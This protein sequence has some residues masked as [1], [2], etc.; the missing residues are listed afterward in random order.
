MQKN[1]YLCSDFCVHIR[2]RARVRKKILSIKGVQRCVVFLFLFSCVFP[3]KAQIHEAHPSLF[4]ASDSYH[5]G[6]V[7]VG[8]GYTNLQTA[9]PNVTP[10]GDVGGL[11]GIG[12]EYRNRFL[13][14][15]A[16]VQMSLFHSSMKVG[17]ER[18]DFNG[19]DTQGKKA[20]FHYDVSQRDQLSWTMFDLPL[21]AG[22]YW[23]G[24]QVGVG[25]KLSY[26][27]KPMTHTDGTYTLSATNEAYDLVFEN[28]PEFG[29]TDYQVSCDA[30]NRVGFGVGLVGE[31]GYDL[32][33]LMYTNSRLCHL[34]TVSFYFEYG[35]TNALEKN[36]TPV[37]RLQ[38]TS[39][40]EDATKATI[41]PI[42]NTFST[43]ARTVPYFTGLKIT[44]FIGGNTSDQEGGF[45]R[46]C[47]CYE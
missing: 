42:M 14:A 43:P 3:I 2:M 1:V 13:W 30:S 17:E 22:Y 37:N 31:L 46:G 25:V 10:A 27:V 9:I 35:L 38:L 29:Y 24:L 39:P 11:A 32:M 34:L 20:V 4:R 18:F 40:T 44:Y 5:F 16:G 21:M 36:P 45:H 26:A 19:Y 41:Q 15:R 12:Y 7:S 23:H 28:R 33:S 8:A 47:R 6:Y